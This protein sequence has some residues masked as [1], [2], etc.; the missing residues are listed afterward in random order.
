MVYSRGT[1]V[2]ARPAC[3]S[4]RTRASARSAMTSSRL[5]LSIARDA[6][7]TSR[8]ADVSG[9]RVAVVGHELRTRG[10][11]HRPLHDGH[12][13]GP[14]RARG[15]GGGDHRS[16]ALSGVA[17]ARRRLAAVDERTGSPYG[18]WRTMPR[19]SALTRGRYEWSFLRRAS[20][21][22]S[23]RAPR[24]SGRR[25]PCTRRC[26][27]RAQ[28]GEP[29]QDPLCRHR[30]GPR[31]QGAS[32]SG[33]RGGGPVAG[34]VGWA[35]RAGPERRSRGRNDQPPDGSNGRGV[36]G[37]PR[38]HRLSAQLHAH[39]DATVS[40]HEARGRLGWSQDRFIALH[41]G[42]MGFKQDWTTSSRPRGSA[43]HSRLE[44]RLMGDGNQRVTYPRRSRAAYPGSAS[45]IRCR[46]DDYPLGAVPQ[47]RAARQR[48]L[49][50]R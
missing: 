38:P 43:G 49:D 21:R 10:H 47:R 14:R 44:F 22:S 50:G 7:P 34:A 17:G 39:R 41:T 40:R 9:L 6:P 32:Q 3:A 31:R 13:R 35:E 18:G 27:R 36:R 5:F 4:R 23:D 37:P 12:V 15:D 28:S 46:K 45:W 8:T 42:N 33:I 25:G 20:G 2:K 26:P 30:P 16:S 11:R 48:A 24:R 19:M 1:A 29:A